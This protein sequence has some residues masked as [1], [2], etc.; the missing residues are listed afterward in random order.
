MSQFDVLIGTCFIVDDDENNVKLC[1]KIVCDMREWSS[2]G[3]KR[4]GGVGV[5]FHIVS[6]GVLRVFSPTMCKRAKCDVCHIVVKV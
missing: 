5:C 3:G 1:V 4:H 2:Q 6:G